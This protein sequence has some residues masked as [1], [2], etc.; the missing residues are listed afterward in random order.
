MAH[1]L[2]SLRHMDCG[3]SAFLQ[4]EIRCRIDLLVSYVRGVN[5]VDFETVKVW[6]RREGYKINLLLDSPD[7]EVV[8]MVKGIHR[9]LCEMGFSFR[10]V[11]TI[12]AGVAEWLSHD[13]GCCDNPNRF[14]VHHA[15][16]DHT[17]G[18]VNDIQGAML[19]PDYVGF[20]HRERNTIG[21]LQE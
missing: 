9:D 2:I 13:D 17:H 6:F 16:D 8:D 3:G 7:D 15:T 12:H 1:T 18:L 11:T 21:Y 20:W 10:S 19:F 4:H 5:S 14:P